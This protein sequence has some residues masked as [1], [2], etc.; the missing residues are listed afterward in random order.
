MA[1]MIGIRFLAKEKD[2]PLHVF[3]MIDVGGSCMEVRQGL[4]LITFV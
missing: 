3:Q 4:M 1:W 2:F